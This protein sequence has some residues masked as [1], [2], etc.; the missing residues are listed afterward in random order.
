M[1]RWGPS[2]RNQRVCAVTD[3]TQVMWAL[4]KG[5]SKN[6]FSMVWLR[7]I[8]WLS[9]THNFVIDSVYI[10]THDNILCDSLSRLDDEESISKI[11]ERM[12]EDSMCCYHLFNDG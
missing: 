11:K 5:R 2:W 12:S 6:K 8:F 4:R 10:S 9:V 3:N 1:E 7:E